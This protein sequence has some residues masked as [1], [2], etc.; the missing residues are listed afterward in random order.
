MAAT[1]KSHCRWDDLIVWEPSYKSGAENEM[2]EKVPKLA[3]G[4]T[5]FEK[6]PPAVS[7]VWDDVGWS[8]VIC[9]LWKTEFPAVR[10][11]TGVWERGSKGPKIGRRSHRECPTLG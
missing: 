7:P 8:L 1:R 3:K 10:S 2:G 4:P 6:V 9:G 11:Q 5:F